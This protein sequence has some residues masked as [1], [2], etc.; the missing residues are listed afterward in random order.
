MMRLLIDQMTAM[1]K[2][3]I[4]VR[5]YHIDDD[6]KCYFLAGIICD[7]FSLHIICITHLHTY[8]TSKLGDEDVEAE[9]GDKIF[10]LPIERSEEDNEQGDNPGK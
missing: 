4:L 6:F 10:Y 1:T 3:L 5:E 7:H 8:C 9:R 2:R